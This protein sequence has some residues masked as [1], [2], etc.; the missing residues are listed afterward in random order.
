MIET[1]ARRAPILFLGQNWLRFLPAGGEIS[2]AGCQP[3][4]SAPGRF[5]SGR[6]FAASNCSPPKLFHSRLPIRERELERVC[7]EG[8]FL[9][10]IPDPIIPGYETV[11]GSLGH[12]LGVG[13]GVAMGL[14]MKSS[15]ASVYVLLGDGELHEGAVW[16]AVMF[17]AQ[18]RLGN[19]MAIVDQNGRAMLG[20]C[21]E[22]DIRSSVVAWKMGFARSYMAHYGISGEL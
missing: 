17:A 9:G 7:Q 22:Y 10:G 6:C 5:Q 14:R 4:R 2:K 8:S 18:H 15:S 13:C 20:N 12:G 21:W 16:E 3:A 1:G 19:L 11:N